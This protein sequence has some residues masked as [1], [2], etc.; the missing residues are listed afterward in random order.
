VVLNAVWTIWRRNKALSPARNQ[1]TIRRSSGH[2]AD[3]AT[4]APPTQRGRKFNETT[5]AD[6]M[7]FIA[8]PS[9]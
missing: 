4:Q 9:Y 2:Y 3:R 6:R 1:T 8:I 5:P 7:L